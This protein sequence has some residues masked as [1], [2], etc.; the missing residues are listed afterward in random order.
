M[1]TSY[2]PGDL[3]RFSHAAEPGPDS[4]ST[5]MVIETRPGYWFS[6]VVVLYDG[7]EMVISI[8]EYAPHRDEAGFFIR[9]THL[10]HIE[11]VQRNV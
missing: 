2:K 9:S 1:I 11:L 8:K 7:S 4:W 5:A 6:A 3:V 10:P